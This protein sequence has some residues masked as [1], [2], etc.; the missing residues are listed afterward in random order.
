MIV[1]VVLGDP[2]FGFGEGEDPNYTRLHNAAKSSALTIKHP[3]PESAVKFWCK[4][5]LVYFV[6]FFYSINLSSIHI[7]NLEMES[8]TKLNFTIQ[9]LS[10][11]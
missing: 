5:P 8:L 1:T 11:N 4:N 3:P 9:R 6:Q 2:V 7:L 10:R